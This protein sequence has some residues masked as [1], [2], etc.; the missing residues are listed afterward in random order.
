MRRAPS[1]LS[2]VEG[3]VRGGQGG[4]GIC[5]AKGVPRR[6]LVSGGGSRRGRI[7]QITFRESGQKIK[8]GS[9]RCGFFGHRKPDVRPAFRPRPLRYF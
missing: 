7:K 2:G 9:A 5:A 6:E 1:T 4:N 3:G 8:P